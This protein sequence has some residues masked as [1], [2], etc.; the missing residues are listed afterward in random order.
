MYLKNRS[1]TKALNAKTPE[2]MWTNE[3]P[4]VSHLRVF[5]CKCYVHTPKIHRGKLDP[6]ST[7]GIFVGFC[8]GSKG[9]RIYDPLTKRITKSRDVIF[10]EKKTNSQSTPTASDEMILLDLPSDS[11][12]QLDSPSE[13]EEPAISEPRRS[14]RERRMPDYYGFPSV[15]L[16]MEEPTT[17]AKAMQS[18]EREAWK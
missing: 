15:N 7:E 17:L 9:Y 4:N 1:P 5:G 6:K 10:V 3:K 12:H 18:D 8:D 13:R 2:E 11:M 16:M 14:T